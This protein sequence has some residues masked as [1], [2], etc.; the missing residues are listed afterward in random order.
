[1]HHYIYALF[2]ADAI[3]GM[4]NRYSHFQLN[5][6]Y[7]QKNSLKFTRIKLIDSNMLTIP[8]LANLVA[9]IYYLVYKYEPPRANLFKKDKFP[10][11]ETT[12][13]KFL[14]LTLP[15]WILSY[16]LFMVV[17]TIDNWVFKP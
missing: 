3:L 6:E 1:M 10:M 7:P 17:Y 16:C 4:F 9:L 8:M 11:T 14:R 2:T 5:G 13:K 12:H 15:K